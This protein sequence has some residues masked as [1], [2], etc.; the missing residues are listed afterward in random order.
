MV[1]RN[2]KPLKIR[3]YVPSQLKPLFEIANNFSFAWSYRISEIFQSIDP[4]LFKKCK[5][6]PYRMLMEVDKSVLDELNSNKSFLKR[7]ADAYIHYEVYCNEGLN[8]KEIAFPD[9]QR[10]AYFCAE[11]GLHES[12]PNYSGGLGVLA[13]DHI[14]TASDINMPLLAVGLLYRY[15]YFSQY[16][17]AEGWQQEKY[18]VLDT[19]SVPLEIICDDKQNPVLIPVDFPGR[20]VYL[21]V[22]KAKIGNVPLYLLDA[23][24]AE[25][26][27]DDRKITDMLYIA[28]KEMR[29]QQ[30]LLLG[31]GGVR[32]LKKM[33]IKVT[34]YHMNEG[35]SAFSAL[36]RMRCFMAERKLSFNQAL[37]L[38]KSSALFT[39]HTSV[40]AGNEQFSDELLEKY[41]SPLIKTL[42][43][44]MHKFLNFGK[45]HEEKGE[46]FGMTPF[47]IRIAAYTNGVSKLHG[48]VSR[49]L[50]KDIWKELFLDEIPIDH[51]TNGVHVPTWLSDE[52]S[53]LFFRYVDP[54]W[55]SKIGDP[56][57]WERIEDIPA[58]ELWKSQERLKDRLIAFVR[59]RIRHALIELHV[60]AEEIQDSENLLNVDALTIGFA[61]RFATYK[62]AN[63]LFKDK[64]RLKKIMADKSR[65]V[66]FI[67]A[68]KAHPADK[69]GKKLIQEIIQLAREEGFKNRLVFIEDYDL[70]IAR[71]LVQGVD[72][73]LNTPR[74]PDEA[75]GTSGMKVGINGGV[76]L[77]VA[78]GWWDEA[79]ANDIGY[80][81]GKGEEYEDH[82]YQDF[83]ESQ[84]LYDILENSVI[85][86][87]Y[88]RGV[89]NLPKAWIAKIK[90]SLKYCIANFN[91][92]RMLKEYAEKYYNPASVR[93]LK[94]IQDNFL[95]L[96]EYESW[97]S[98]IQKFWDKI[99]IVDY[100][101]KDN[102]ESFNMGDNPEFL[103]KI[104]LGELKEKDIKVSLFY[105]KEEKDGKILFDKSD[106][107]DFAR[108]ENDVSVFSKKITLKKG[109]KFFYTV[110]V[111]PNHPMRSRPLEPGYIKWA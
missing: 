18:Y 92:E 109:G 74:R 107:L 7:L 66:Q 80:T 60:T 83:V 4:K 9:G 47:S 33:G 87:Y 62:R 14:K 57:M 55:I 11:F 77:S 12:F 34:T 32:F 31:I 100:G 78:D 89:D 48:Y 44:D 110:Q 45:V 56:K 50:W 24:I 25:N 20:I 75:C 37:E 39:T 85:P 102:Q 21:Q 30:E 95:Q 43:I 2:Y 76:N 35:H 6:N 71:Y 105:G 90:Q 13:G 27:F 65:P 16:L 17:S 69:E 3:P 68:G 1:H 36:E 86:A 26:S 58:N 98:I 46:S 54:D 19:F 29:L 97:L 49:N 15:G 82:E 84:A 94:H 41:L 22:W 99:E 53:R 52:F 81:I 70:E 38:V 103:C 61:R 5:N 111:L 8:H 104:K 108:K 42:G 72:V 40:P 88:N 73:W 59:K 10:I 101:S 96:K 51:I 106:E 79:Y 91:S 63:L 64:E 67:F 28:D 93:H 23:N